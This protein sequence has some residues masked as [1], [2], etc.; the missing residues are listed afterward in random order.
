MPQRFKRG[1]SLLMTMS[2]TRDIGSAIKAYIT[3]EHSGA[4]NFFNA[5][6]AKHIDEIGIGSESSFK[7]Y[8]SNIFAGRL[9]GTTSSMRKNEANLRKLSI[10]LW[11]AKMDLNHEIIKDIK[12]FDPRFQYPPR[13][14]ESKA[15]NKPGSLEGMVV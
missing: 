10:V 9:Y 7:K 1:N 2:D 12:D 13:D 8:M 14:Y 11:Y 3:S 6:M 15:R 4:V 5:V